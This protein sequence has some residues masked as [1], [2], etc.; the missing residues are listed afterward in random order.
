[1]TVTPAKAGIQV[2]SQDCRARG[3]GLPA[4]ACM[5]DRFPCGTVLDPQATRIALRPGAGNPMGG[6][7]KEET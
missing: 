6:G 4:S 5:M 2:V 1:M 3:N 7:L